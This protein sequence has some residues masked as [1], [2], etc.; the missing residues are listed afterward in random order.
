MD[1]ALAGGLIGIALA[2]LMGLVGA[3]LRG[4]SEAKYMSRKEAM[5]AKEFAHRAAHLASQEDTGSRY[6]ASAY[7]DAARKLARENDGVLETVTGLHV[8][9]LRNA[10]YG[11]RE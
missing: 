8:D 10:L 6:A 4:S 3:A 7:F 9:Q 11:K 2:V 5:L 1:Y